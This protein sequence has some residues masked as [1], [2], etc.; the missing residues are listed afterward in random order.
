MDRQQLISPNKFAYVNLTS[1]EYGVKL[2][3]RLA[4]EFTGGELVGFAPGANVS[5]EGADPLSSSYTRKNWVS[6]IT[7]GSLYAFRA[8]RIP[9]Q[10]LIV[11]ELHGRLRARDMDAVA[12]A[13]AIAIANLVSKELPVLSTEGWSVQSQVTDRTRVVTRIA[14]PFAAIALNVDGTLSIEEDGSG[15]ILGN[16]EKRLEAGNATVDKALTEV[17]E[18]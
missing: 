6:G 10:H 13:A 1:G 17:T 3:L 4:D 7:S 11:S 5:L 2:E 15:M 16:A 14:P 12:N 8:L 18:Q 9:R